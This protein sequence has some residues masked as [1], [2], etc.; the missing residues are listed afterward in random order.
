MKT[1]EV[2][3][4]RLVILKLLI[5]KLP[6][7]NETLF[8]SKKLNDKKWVGVTT[9]PSSFPPNLKRLFSVYVLSY[10]L[11]SSFSFHQAL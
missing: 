2:Q 9:L 7:L 4:Q 10:Y 11:Y 1:E 5:L 8:I 6:N 3:L